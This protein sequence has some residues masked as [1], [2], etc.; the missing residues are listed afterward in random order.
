[1]KKI[2]RHHQ[3]LPALYYRRIGQ[4]SHQ[5]NMVEVYLQL[6]VWHYLD[7][8]YKQGRLLTYWPGARGKIQ[9]FQALAL[10]WVDEADLKVE[11]R[12]IAKQAEMLNVDRN[13]IVHGIWGFENDS[14][15]LYLLHISNVKQRILP[16]V[17]RKSSEDLQSTA[18]EIIALKNR[19]I[20]L[21]KNLGAAIP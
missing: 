21:H 15:E 18:N 4:I 20:A 5:W 13:K 9:I 7:L 17:T 12:A 8:D 11:I 1:M 16:G 14:N 6:I 3:T 2:F 10:H 19:L